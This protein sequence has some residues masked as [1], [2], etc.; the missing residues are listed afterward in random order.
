MSR[1]QLEGCL[2]AECFLTVHVPRYLKQALIALAWFDFGLLFIW[3]SIVATLATSYGGFSTALG[4]LL[5]AEELEARD[6]REK[7]HS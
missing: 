7:S 6:V 3:M 1:L 2:P 4:D 5:P